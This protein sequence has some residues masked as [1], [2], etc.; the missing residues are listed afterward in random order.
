MRTGSILLAATLLVPAT[1]TIG[2]ALAATP[3][4]AATTGTV[5]FA[6]AA[7]R[8]TFEAGSGVVNN[9]RVSHIGSVTEIEDLNHAITIAENAESVCIQQGPKKVRCL[10]PDLV[11]VLL[12]NDNDIGTVLRNND[13]GVTVFGQN[14]EDDLNGSDGDDVLNGGNGDDTIDGL[15]GDDTLRGGFGNDTLDGSGGTDAFFGGPNA[16]LIISVD[17]TPEVVNCGDAIFD[18]ADVAVADADDIL[19]NCE[20]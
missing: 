5:S 19:I 7:S 10:E 2:L 6:S 16:D 9:V 1:T 12:G 8:L 4:T 15:L 17:G 13:A 14:G 20:A 18:Q 11:Q 3:A